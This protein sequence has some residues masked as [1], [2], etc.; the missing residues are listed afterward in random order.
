MCTLK[1]LQKRYA[2]YS[3]VYMT[4]IFMVLLSGKFQFDP[5][6]Y[7]HFDPVS[8]F[9]FDPDIYLYSDPVSFVHFDPVSS[10]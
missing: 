4:I 2:V 6:S 8:Y 5:V 10:V 7:F 1:T 3:R 9:H